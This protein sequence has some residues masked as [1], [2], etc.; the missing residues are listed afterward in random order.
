MHME[1]VLIERARAPGTA[2]NIG[3]QQVPLPPAP[4][5]VLL[6]DAPWP[7]IDI[8]YTW[9]NGSDPLMAHG[10]QKSSMYARDSVRAAD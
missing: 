2:T 5:G 3:G 8:V 10:M 6:E 7:T 4:S 1:L 9:V